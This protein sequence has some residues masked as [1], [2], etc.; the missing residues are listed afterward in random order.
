MDAFH[1]LVEVWF[2][3]ITEVTKSSKLYF[4]F[5]STNLPLF[6]RF[7]F[8]FYFCI[9][10][11]LRGFDDNP[12]LNYFSLTY[13]NFVNWFDWKTK[14]TSVNDSIWSCDLTE[15]KSI[16]LRLTVAHTGNNRL[17]SRQDIQH[18]YRVRKGLTKLY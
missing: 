6:V 8:I 1:I 4:A 12:I 3:V 10:N 16:D 14:E 13:W 11:L 18:C 17:S 15:H 2:M 9:S 5:Q 7:S